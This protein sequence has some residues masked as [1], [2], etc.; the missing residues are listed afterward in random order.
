M[1]PSRPR[2]HEDDADAGHANA[3]AV[4]QR[5]L[6]AAGTGL[7]LQW[8]AGNSRRNMSFEDWID[9]QPRYRRRI[10]LWLTLG[11]AVLSVIQNSIKL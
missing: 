7:G 5:R 10:Y 8:L 3:Q 6:E 11:L 4:H 2:A 9:K 1:V